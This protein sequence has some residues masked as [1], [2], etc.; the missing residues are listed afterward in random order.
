MRA[1]AETRSVSTGPDVRRHRKA[2]RFN[3]AGSAPAQKGEA[4]G[5]GRMRARTETRS[6]ST[7]QDAQQA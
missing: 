1:R 4:L 7:G 2:K 5:Q 3:R 6:V